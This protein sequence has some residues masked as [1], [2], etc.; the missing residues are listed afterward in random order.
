MPL[1]KKVTLVDIFDQSKL[2]MRNNPIV[3]T[4]IWWIFSI[5]ERK[6]L[7]VEIFLLLSSVAPGHWEEFRQAV[8]QK[9][10]PCL[11]EFYFLICF[12]AHLYEEFEETVV[13][14]FAHLPWP[15]TN[16]GYHCEEQ[17][18]PYYSIFRA[19]KGVLLLY[20]SPL[21][22]L[23]QYT[24]VIFNHAFA[25]NCAV[26][27]GRSVKWMCNRVDD[28]PQLNATLNRLTSGHVKLL[29]LHFCGTEVRISSRGKNI[30]DCFFVC[31]CRHFFRTT[32]PFQ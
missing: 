6:E 5:K 25:Q 20:T 31:F 21:Q 24:R 19:T 17:I 1:V 14:T 15:L 18:L 9:D 2:F 13:Q 30:D 16:L 23:S 32:A 10:F 29:D 26:I 11:G 8:Q 12:P 22:I 4:K 28:V 3:R 7:I 27:N